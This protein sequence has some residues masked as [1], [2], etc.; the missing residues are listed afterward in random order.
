M[1]LFLIL[2]FGL[3]IGWLITILFSFILTLILYP[4]DKKNYTHPKWK[5]LFPLFF[6]IEYKVRQKSGQNLIYTNTP[7][8]L[9][10][11]FLGDEKFT[12]RREVFTKEYIESDEFKKL[13]EFGQR[14]TRKK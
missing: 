4:F 6:T 5:T 12:I 7:S 8:G 13:K 14:V 2:G 11:P 1:E 10:L 9:G 3:I